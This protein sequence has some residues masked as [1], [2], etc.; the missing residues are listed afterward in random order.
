MF[1]LTRIVPIVAAVSLVTLYVGV[2]TQVQPGGSPAT[3]AAES[4]PPGSAIVWDSGRVRLTAAAMRIHAGDEVFTGSVPPFSVH[5]DGADVPTTLEVVWPEQGVEQRMN[6]YFDM[7]G[8]DWWVTELRTFDGDA[9]RPSWIL[10]LGTPVHHP[11][12][13]GILR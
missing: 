3:G 7:N 9:C 6:L 1:A 13:P 2:S 4:P 11:P 10:L 12:R 5:S 8:T